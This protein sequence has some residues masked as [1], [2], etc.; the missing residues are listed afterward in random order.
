VIVR[1]AAS[2]LA[3]FLVVLAVLSAVAYSFVDHVYASEVSPALA[4]PETQQALHRAMTRVLLFIL[5]VDVP[6]ALLVAVASY[7]L[8][9]LSIA[10]LVAAR[11][12]EAQFAADAAHELR[13]PLAKIAAIAQAARGSDEGEEALGTITRT[14]ID[15]STMVGEL[16][17]LLRSEELNVRAREPVDLGSVLL[18]T[19]R[20]Y[21]GAAATRSIDFDVKAAS[22][23][24]DGEELRLRQLAGNLIDNALRHA[25]TKAEAWI[26]TENDWARLCVQDDGDGVPEALRERVFERFFKVHESAG[27]TGLGLAIC[28]WVARAHG[29]DVAMENGSRFV[30]RIPLLRTND[31][32]ASL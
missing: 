13:T 8:A 15:A 27:G 9:R 25:K 7:L 30:A 26:E 20:D 29:G 18:A 23:I 6:L 32:E 22:A 2:Y 11:K 24:V 28:R 10:P 17:T 16:L 31:K 3:V 12:R 5:A 14:A 1:L 21:A 4:L 19:A